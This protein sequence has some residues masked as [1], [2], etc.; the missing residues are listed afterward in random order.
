[1]SV[2]KSIETLETLLTRR[3]NAKLIAMAMTVK[4]MLDNRAS[5]EA[6]KD[7]VSQA[8]RQAGLQQYTKNDASGAKDA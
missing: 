3:Q 7:Y 5:T 1:M 8:M 4:A 2:D 6:M